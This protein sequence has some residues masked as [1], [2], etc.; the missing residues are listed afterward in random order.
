MRNSIKI[1]KVNINFNQP[2][3][4]HIIA[5]MI[6][7]LCLCIAP[8]MT[9]LNGYGNINFFYNRNDHLFVIFFAGIFGCISNYI[10][11]STKSIIHGL[12]F[13]IVAIVLSFIH[14]MVLFSCAT[15]W[16]GL[17]IVIVNLLFNLSAFYLKT[18]IRRIYGFIG[19]YSSALLGIA[20]GIIIYFLVLK[21]MYHFKILYLL[22]IIFLLLFFLKNSY[23]L[24]TSLTSQT[25]RINI[26][27][28]GVLL[29]FFIFAFI[30]FYL[31]V[32]LN[33]FSSLNLVILPLSL[34]YLHVITVTNNKENGKNLLKYIYFS[35]ALIVINKIFYLS[36]LRYEDVVD[37][38]YLNSAISTFLFLLAEYLL[39][40]IIYFGWRFKFIA[41][42]IESITNSHI[43]KTM[44][45]IEAI[46]VFILI[47]AIFT[48]NILISNI[49]LIFATILSLVLNIFIVPIYFSLGKILAGGK[50]EI[51]TTTLIYLIF[52]SLIF[53]SFLYDISI[54]L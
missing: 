21:N 8:F 16:I 18:D 40:I 42:R 17:A 48:N 10:F 23:K 2:K 50:N 52:S 26:S 39:C 35:L 13:I 15:L 11:G 45:Y 43:I 29:I 30:L 47:T 31:L 9:I 33:V 14:N 36:F 38:I 49:I 7:C 27:F 12:Q 32:N 4:L 25:E 22:I 34:I 51:I 41:L 54:S 46:R 20:T 3:G 19:V 37:P 5:F 44:L 24:N 53:V 28:Y 6:F 1:S